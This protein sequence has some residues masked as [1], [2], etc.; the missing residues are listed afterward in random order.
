MGT[1]GTK[2]TENDSTADTLIDWGNKYFKKY[3][4]SEGYV[5]FKKSKNNED[6]FWK[7]FFQDG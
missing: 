1:W 2:L 5:D 4:N 3:K 6:R 7:G